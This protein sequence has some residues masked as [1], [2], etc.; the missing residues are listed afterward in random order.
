MRDGLFFQIRYDARFRRYK[1]YFGTLT[2][3]HRLQNTTT[4]S[5]QFDVMTGLAT[6]SKQ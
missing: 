2:L 6:T 5:M 1:G 4:Y 3:L